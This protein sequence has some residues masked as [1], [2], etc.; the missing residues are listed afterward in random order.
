MATQPENYCLDPSVPLP[1]GGDRIRYFRCSGHGLREQ[2]GAQTPVG[3]SQLSGSAVG[4]KG[5]AEAKK[6]AFREAGIGV[7]ETPSEMAGTLL[8]MM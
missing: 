7:A 4:G 5:T 1:A 3:D 2:L 6:E 8:Q